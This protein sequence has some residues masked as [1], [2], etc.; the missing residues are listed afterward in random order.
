MPKMYPDGGRKLARTGMRN[1]L[2]NLHGLILSIYGSLT[3]IQTL[4]K[5]KSSFHVISEKI[6]SNIILSKSGMY[7]LFGKWAIKIFKICLSCYFF[8]KSVQFY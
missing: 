6:F 7:N 5:V 2:F 8:S 3:E 4:L 1:K